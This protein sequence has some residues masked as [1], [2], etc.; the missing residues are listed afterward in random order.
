VRHIDFDPDA[1]AEDDQAWF[2]LWSDKAADAAA[3]NNLLAPDAK[4]QWK[5]AVWGEFKTWLLSRVFAGKCAYC[6]SKYDGNSFGA[7]EHYRPKGRVTERDGKRLIPVARAGVTHRGYFWLAYTWWNLVPSCDKCNSGQGKVDQFPILGTRV[8]AESEVPAGSTRE[9]LKSTEEPLLLNPY[10]DDP[11]QHLIF[12][13][14]GVIAARMG[15]PRGQATIDVCNLTRERL[16]EDRS[17]RQQMAMIALKASVT[18]WKDNNFD[19][20]YLDSFRQLYLSQDREFSAA[21][22]ELF[23]DHIAELHKN[24]L[25]LIG[26]NH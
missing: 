21:V 17:E 15:S 9:Q 22:Q 7:A 23:D 24:L 6:E 3:I 5:E 19:P 2:K 11:S 14:H 1:L 25:V 16:A 4:P 13:K 20:S 8:F 12:G 18:A 26:G 10:D